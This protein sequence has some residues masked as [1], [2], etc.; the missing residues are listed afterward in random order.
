M[1]AWWNSL[2][3][4]EQAFAYLAIPATLILVI[5]T[6]LLLFGLG[7]DGDAD[8]DFEPDTSGLD[9]DGIYPNWTATF[10]CPARW[11][12]AQTPSGTATMW[13]RRP[14]RGCGSSPSVVS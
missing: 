2:T 11:M 5:Q 4:L 10:P 6:L 9:L 12:P 7:H 13:T 8:V 14:T 3:G 1:V